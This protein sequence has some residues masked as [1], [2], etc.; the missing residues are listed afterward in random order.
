MFVHPRASVIVRIHDSWGLLLKPT[1]HQSLLR[2]G[3][4]PLIK[5]R[6]QS[7]KVCPPNQNKRNADPISRGFF[8]V[9]HRRPC[10]LPLFSF[11]FK[12]S[13]VKADAIPK[14][15]AQHEDAFI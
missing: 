7:S 1:D 13:L 4:N 6:M 12:D 9:Q 5:Q 11:L 2:Y 3:E 8:P 10:D 14:Q 15:V